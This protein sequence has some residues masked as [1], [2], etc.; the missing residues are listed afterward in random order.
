MRKIIEYTLIS[1]D[2]V[3]EGQFTTGFFQYPDDAYL[4]TDCEGDL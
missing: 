2:G 4:R 1:I 3:F